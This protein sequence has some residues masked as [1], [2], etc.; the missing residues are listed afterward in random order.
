MES[1]PEP[2]KKFQIPQ[3]K[4]DPN[5][6]NLQNVH[7]IRALRL[8]ESILV[9]ANVDQITSQKNK[10]RQSGQMD[11]PDKKKASMQDAYAKFQCIKIELMVARKN[12]CNDSQPVQVTDNLFIGSMGGACSRDNLMDKGITHV[13]CCFD[14]KFF[15]FDDVFEYKHVPVL[16]SPT[17]DLGK[18]FDETNGF[19]DAALKKNPDSKFF[20]HCFAGISRSSTVLSAY[21]MHSKKITRLQALEKIRVNRKQAN[22]NTGFVDQQIAYEMKILA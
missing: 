17:E 12:I 20:I 1:A 15:P 22:P 3:D 7:T 18:F 5:H 6:P 11:D 8:L 16:D 9:K 14:K 19:I 10:Q 21:L 13:Q 4:I 2:P